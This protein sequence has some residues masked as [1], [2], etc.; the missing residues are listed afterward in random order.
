[1][2]PEALLDVARNW[3]EGDPDPATREELQGL[4]DRSEIGEL[5]ERMAG[6]LRFGT[7]GLR[8]RVEAGSNRMNRAVVI[9][10]TRGIA[11]Y[12]ADR[13]P[14]SLIVVGR[15]AR[16]SSERLMQDTVGVLAAA[17]FEVRYFPGV[18]PTPLV[19]FAARRLQARMAVVVTASHNPPW[20]NGYKVYDGNG[21][22]IV[23]P[24]DADIAAAIDAVGP[25]ATTA[26]I[27]QPYD[28]GVPSVAPVP[29]DMFGW[30]LDE[31]A[32]ARVPAP[33]RPL[34]IVHTPLHGVGGRFVTEALQRLG[35]HTV[36]PVA[37]QIEPD[38][39]FPTVE[40]PNP[41]EPGALDLALAAAVEEDAD[42]VIANDPDTD[43]LAVAVP[44]GSGWRRL[45]GNQIGL[46]L[47]D[48]SLRLTSVGQPLVISSIVSSP[49]LGDI[50]TAH[51]ARFA[52]TLTG[53][54][55]IW[56]AGLDLEEA[57]DGTF[58]FGFEEALG[59]SV[60]PTVR[61]KD[62]I[63]A[64]VAFADLVAEAVSQGHHVVDVLNAL[65]HRHGLW[66]SI[67]RSVVRPGTEG[68]A[69]IAAAV[70]RAAAV[71]IADLGGA[72][73]AATT[74]FREGA[75]ARPRYLAAASLIQ[76]DLASG[77]RVLVRPSGTEPKLKIYV[78]LRADLADTVDWR[79]AEQGLLDEANRAAMALVEHLGLTS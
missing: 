14:G 45:T 76:F 39:R 3:I 74:D 13:A 34:R 62:G 28:A 12:L 10:A 79:D 33:E 19:A 9:R 59:Y 47:A 11:E 23:P 64:A 65:Y 70:D 4:L 48:R 73:I 37:E 7:A 8:G 21:A 24:V 1:M 38:G 61:D 46:L 69:E 22:Q 31:V 55:W 16:L 17:G 18:T 35:G 58:V 44:D 27:R 68:A 51:G 72:A 53:F 54:K 78:D 2:D 6:T 63:S 60:G 25:A 30:Y 52:T 75:A 43:R 5:T 41:E 40:F 57:G 71:P 50:A 49:M 67:Q 20:D 56:N 29:D 26:R 66:V 32:D 77:G 42:V 15:D 36:I